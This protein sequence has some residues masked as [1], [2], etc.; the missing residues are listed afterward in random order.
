MFILHDLARS[1]IEN[2]PSALAQLHRCVIPDRNFSHKD[3]SF[4]LKKNDIFLPQVA[5]FLKTG[6]G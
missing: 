4:D 6:I 2:Y 1:R 3:N 5:D